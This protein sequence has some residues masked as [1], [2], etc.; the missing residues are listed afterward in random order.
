[1]KGQGGGGTARGGGK[2]R[3]GG[4]TVKTTKSK[5]LQTKAV[6]D[7][8]LR[9]RQALF[10]DDGKDKNV[11]AGI[12]PSFLK[13]DRSGANVSISLSPKLNEDEVDW[14][15]ELAKSNMEDRYDTSGYG[16]DDEDKERELTEGGARF[17]L[18]RSVE[19]EELIGFAHFRFTVQ[20]EVLDQMIGE[21]CLYVMDL[22]MEEAFQRKGLGRH[23][24]VLL[25]LIARREQMTRVSFPVYLGD[26][27]TQAWVT[28]QRGY[29]VD[30]SFG[31]LGFD[32]DMEVCYY[33]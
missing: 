7:K 3:S 6:E 29:V 12:A 24:L 20:G 11:L 1:M 4:G 9:L 18:I 26:E 15:F 16:W 25:E 5:A 19:T 31:S 2:S 8:V 14:A 17:L 10:N 33:Y 23:L 30:D 22:H 27:S 32:P 21:P 13:F 28:K